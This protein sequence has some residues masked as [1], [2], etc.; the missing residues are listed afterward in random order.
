MS[1]ANIYNFLLEQ[2][3]NIRSIPEI[4]DDLA[5][6]RA[7]IQELQ[8]SVYGPPSPEPD[9]PDVV[10]EGDE[11]ETEERESAQVPPLS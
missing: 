7:E 4:Q 5:Q 3:E 6:I 8:G 10:F 1:I 2:E 9:R 11:D